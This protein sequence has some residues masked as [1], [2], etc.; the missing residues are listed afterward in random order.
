MTTKSLEAKDVKHE[1]ATTSNAVTQGH[2]T[3]TIGRGFENVDLEQITMPRGKLLQ[4]NSPEVSDRDYNLRAGD[5]VHTLLMEKVPEKFI[6]LSIWDSNIMFVPRAEDRKL[7]MKAQ[8]NLTDEDM[9]GMVICRSNDAKTGDKYGDCKA[10]GLCKF[11]GNEKPWCNSTIN[12][13]AVPYEGGALGMPV[14]FQFANTSY[15]HGKK[16]RDTAFY[17]SLGADLFSRVYKLESVQSQANGNTWYEVKVK[18]AGIVPDEVK[19]EVESMYK[20]FASKQIVVEADED[21]PTTD[22]S[23]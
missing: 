1:I 12:V 9:A 22:S 18:P 2:G 14:V 3:T 4:S 8:L 5:I 20:S 10:C 6:A 13:L 17:S 15:K 19:S 21:T 23:Y 7:S 16:F 11:D